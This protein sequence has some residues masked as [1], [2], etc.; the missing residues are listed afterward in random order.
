MVNSKLKGKGFTVA[1]AVIA[2][3]LGFLLVAALMR[4]FGSA[5]NANQG[6]PADPIRSEA[7]TQQ[8]ARVA[9][10]GQEAQRG[11]EPAAAAQP[12]PAPT[13]DSSVLTRILGDS[14]TPQQ[15][16]RESEA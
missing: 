12:T 4:G 10:Q 9:P 1:V 5:G 14:R 3:A 6:G 8:T 13:R 16:T 11:S 2:L 15:P 7:Q